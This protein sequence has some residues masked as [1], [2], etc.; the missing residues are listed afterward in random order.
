MEERKERKEKFRL[1]V[2]VCMYCIFWVSC[3]GG[4]GKGL[5]KCMLDKII[6]G[7][8]GEEGIYYMYK[9]SV[10]LRRNIDIRLNTTTE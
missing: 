9:Y 10:S 3:C 5:H 4:G 8:G 2:Y 1:P 7:K 6:V